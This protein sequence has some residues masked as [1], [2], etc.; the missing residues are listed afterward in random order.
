M[1][2]LIVIFISYTL[3]CIAKDTEPTTVHTQKE[4]LLN[5]CVYGLVN[6]GRRVGEIGI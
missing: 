6:Q 2:A 4:Q 1:Y 3:I 5:I